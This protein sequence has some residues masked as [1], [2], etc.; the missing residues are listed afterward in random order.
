M[1]YPLL[2]LLKRPP[3]L[4]QAGKIEGSVLHRYLPEHDIHLH[5]TEHDYKVDVNEA[6]RLIVDNKLE[7][8]SWTV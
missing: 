1:N 6:I 8:G 5:V 3:K 7:A 2:T 4:Y